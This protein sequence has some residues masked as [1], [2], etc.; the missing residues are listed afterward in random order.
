MD[1][2]LVKKWG[3]A[4]VGFY[5]FYSYLKHIFHSDPSE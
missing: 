4:N 3:Q 1:K 5:F 2:A